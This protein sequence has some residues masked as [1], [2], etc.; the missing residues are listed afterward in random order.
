MRVCMRIN[1]TTNVGGLG[2]NVDLVRIQ[3]ITTKLTYCL[4][5]CM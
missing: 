4:N 3:L 5:T 2:S 1:V